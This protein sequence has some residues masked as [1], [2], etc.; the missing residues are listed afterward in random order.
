VADRPADIGDDL[1]G[2]VTRD[3]RKFQLR[4]WQGLSFATPVDTGFARSRWTPASGSPIDDALG[5]TID[6]QAKRQAATKQ[7]ATNA[8]RAAAIA[9][10]YTLD[11][12]EIF[13][14]NQTPYILQLNEGSSAQA[15]SRFIEQVIEKTLRSFGR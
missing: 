14:T 2:F 12:G 3:I 7:R 9:A 13:I 8:Q 15:P 11:N 4:L 10:G 6:D 5:G 1:R